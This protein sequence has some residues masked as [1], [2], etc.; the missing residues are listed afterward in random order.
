M[1]RA[2]TLYLSRCFP[3]PRERR[4]VSKGSADPKHI[5]RF[6]YQRTAGVKRKGEGKPWE[7]RRPSPPEGDGEREMCE[8][9][10]CSYV[11]QC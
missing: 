1:K 7:R 10:I 6:S 11:S 9:V 5:W 4:G 8:C 2:R 3:S